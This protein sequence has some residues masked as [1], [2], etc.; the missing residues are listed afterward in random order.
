ML[1]PLC[2]FATARRHWTWLRGV[3]EQHCQ[4]SRE[5]RL[6]RATKNGSC[7]PSLPYVHFVE[8]IRV[9]E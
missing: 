1:V 8:D 4:F 7:T 3:I 2:L 6:H 5:A 9:L